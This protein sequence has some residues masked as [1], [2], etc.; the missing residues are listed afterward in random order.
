INKHDIS[1]LLHL[2]ENKMINIVKIHPNFFASS[3]R[4]IASTKNPEVYDVRDIYLSSRTDFL[5]GA[6]FAYL[7]TLAISFFSGLILNIAYFIPYISFLSVLTFYS[8]NSWK[9]VEE[10][11]STLKSLIHKECR[12]KFKN[13]NYD[14]VGIAEN[15]S[16]DTVVQV[17]EINNGGNESNNSKQD[18]NGNKT[19]VL[20]IAAFAS[21]VLTVSALPYVMNIVACKSETTLTE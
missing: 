1:T 3:W 4:C 18:N 15:D 17:S 11:Y 21:I 5:G 10:R 7:P 9:T 12:S 16:S 19:E 20:C 14:A 8:L 2:A 6:L 13:D